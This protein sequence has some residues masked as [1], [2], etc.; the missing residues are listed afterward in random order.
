M[1]KNFTTSVALSFHKYFAN[2]CASWHQS[3]QCNPLAYV[4]NSGSKRMLFLKWQIWLNRAHG[5]SF[6][7]IFCTGAVHSD[8]G[9]VHEEWPRLCPGILHHS[10]VHLQWP[11]GPEGTDPTSKGHRGRKYL[12][13]MVHFFTCSLV[14]N[15]NPV[16]TSS[17]VF[18]SINKSGECLIW[19]Y[20]TLSFAFR[21]Y[22][23]VFPFKSPSQHGSIMV[24]TK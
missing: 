6:L 2:I 9:P 19:G 14:F 16:L 10:T 3:H 22:S 4:L 11:P 12:H 24:Q 20:S 1:W 5:L 18:D 17:H 7:F 8:E 21:T 23:V 15:T 13:T